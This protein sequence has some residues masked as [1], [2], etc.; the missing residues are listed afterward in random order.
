MLAPQPGTWSRPKVIA[1]RQSEEPTETHVRYPYLC[2]APDGGIVTRY[3]R[4]RVWPDHR[5][6][7][8]EVVRLDPEWLASR[9]D[10]V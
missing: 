6:Y 10:T 8:T 5:E 7:Q 9:A 4:V 1:E 2:Q 3:T